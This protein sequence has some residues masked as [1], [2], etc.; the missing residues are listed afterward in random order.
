MATSPADRSAGFSLVEIM[1]VVVIVGILAAAIVPR[2]NFDTS[3]ERLREE[4][5]RFDV[6]L[7]MAWEQAIIEG[8]SVGV[9]I[10]REAYTFYVYDP[11]DRQWYNLENDSL[12]KRREL[13]EGTYFDLR[14]EDQEIELATGDEDDEDD[15]DLDEV[16]PQVLLLASGEATPFSI[17]V[18]S[19]DTETEFELVVDPFG[20]SEIIEH[21]NDF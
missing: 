9:E 19:D 21:S 12:L 2:F 16:V 10:E 8:R 20:D 18:E 11:L 4:I 13:P 6:L 1:V 17:Y 14:M 5:R 7:S 15:D 3:E